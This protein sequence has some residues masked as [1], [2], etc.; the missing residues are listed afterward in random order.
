MEKIKT[1]EEIAI[2]HGA[3]HCISAYKDRGLTDP[4]CEVHDLEMV[5]NDFASQFKPKWISVSEYLPTQE[6]DYLVFDPVFNAQAVASF[7]NGKWIN[8]VD[9]W[10][11]NEIKYWMPLPEAP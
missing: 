6:D 4:S 1:F 9:F 5:A 3:C 7:Y 11:A 8:H 2:S 10:S